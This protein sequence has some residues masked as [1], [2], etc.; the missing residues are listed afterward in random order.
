MSVRV[1]GDG[2]RVG[3]VGR[4]GRVSEQRPA[5]PHLECLRLARL[6]ADGLAALDAA[7]LLAA[8]LEL[9]RAELQLPQPHAVRQLLAAQRL[10]LG[11][12]SGL[13]LGLGLGLG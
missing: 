5:Q 4:M 8:H 3:R 1:R 12:G 6:L 2:S 7:R 9:A 11:L 10:G 13:G